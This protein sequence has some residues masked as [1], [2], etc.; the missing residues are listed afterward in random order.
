MNCDWVSKNIQLYIYDELA[1]DA[2][3]ELEQHVARCGECAKELK[4]ARDLHSVLSRMPV[5]EPSP[6]LLASSRMK[7]QESLETVEQSGFWRRLVFDP[8]AWWREVR[9]APAV[10]AIIFIVG[11]AGGIGG[12]YQV[13]KYR[14]PVPTSGGSQVEASM[15][16][17][18]RSVS[19]DPGTNQVR[20][21]YDTVA[22]QEVE[23]SLNDQRIQQL[24][25]FAARN[26][27]NSGV[28]MDSVG[29]LSQQPQEAR[30]R[31]ALLYALRYDSNPG[32]RLKALD[33]LGSYVKDDVRVRD[34]VLEVLLH[35]SNQGM[36]TNALHLLGPVRADSSV[37]AVMQQLAD[38]DRNQYIRSQARTVLA[39]LPEID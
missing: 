12:T 20:I 6:N 22:P 15:I 7:L 33:A 35:D 36:R 39:Q 10:A 19:Q 32:V 34:G 17:G 11:L 29:L 8:W 31:E 4:S 28:R 26:N 14:I 5:Q 18:I 30:A 13:M 21:K 3:Y 24:L 16:S 23:G 27:Y 9:F 1:D 25:L 37:R 2:R 38:G